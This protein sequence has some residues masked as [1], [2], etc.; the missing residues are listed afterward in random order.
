MYACMSVILLKAAQKSIGL[1]SVRMAGRCWM[2]KEINDKLKG[3][4]RSIVAKA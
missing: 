3:K 2:T 1:K 4:N